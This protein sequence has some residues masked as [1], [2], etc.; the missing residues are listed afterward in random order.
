MRPWARVGLA[1]PRG[2]APAGIL[3]CVGRMIFA[4]CYTPKWLIWAFVEKAVKLRRFGVVGG[5]WPWIP[6][7]WSKLGL[8]AWEDVTISRF[9]VIL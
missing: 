6:G 5:C 2:C 7:C 8:V 9:G 1:R 3:T 4:G